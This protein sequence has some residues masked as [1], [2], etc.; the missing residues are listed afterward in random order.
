MGKGLIRWLFPSDADLDRALNETM[1]GVGE[2]AELIFQAH[3]LYQS[4]RMARGIKSEVQ[5]NQV[6]VTA[7]ARDPQTGYDYVGVTR[8]GHRKA[9]IEP[10]ADRAR[11]TVMLTGSRRGTVRRGNA[12]LR[13]VIGGRVLY[14]RRVRGFHPAVDWAETAMPQVNQAAEHAMKTLGHRIVVGRL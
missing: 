8:F 10:R 7:V 1:R 2:D 12:S 13:F 3:A 4:G 5:P 9:Y 11:A 14:R 6:V